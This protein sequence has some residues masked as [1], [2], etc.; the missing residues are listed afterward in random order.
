MKSLSFTA[1]YASEKATSMLFSVSCF[2]FLNFHVKT[3]TSFSLQ[4]KQLF[5]IS[6]VAITSRQYRGSPETVAFTDNS[7]RKHQQEAG[8]DGSDGCTSDW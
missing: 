5:E 7:L 2:L 4:V 1:I 6:E 3:G 8:L